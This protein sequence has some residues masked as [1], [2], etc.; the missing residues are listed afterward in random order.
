MNF[1]DPWCSVTFYWQSNGI[2]CSI[3]EHQHCEGNSDHKQS[4][5]I[6]GTCENSS[7][8]RQSPVFG[9][10][11]CSVQEYAT[12]S[13]LLITY[14]NQKIGHHFIV[15]PFFIFSTVWYW[16]RSSSLALS[17]PTLRSHDWYSSAT[18][19]FSSGSRG[20]SAL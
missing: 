15:S 16:V 1:Y 18:L 14:G 9:R 19:L 7:Q 8:K 12:I 3:K 10:F 17:S 20:R 2:W 11:Y 4:K 6:I 13:C 5:N